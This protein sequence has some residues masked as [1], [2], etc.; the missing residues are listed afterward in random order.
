[1]KRKFRFWTA[2]AAAV[3]TA[4]A[5]FVLGFVREDPSPRDLGWLRREVGQGALVHHAAGRLYL[6]ELD[7]GETVYIAPGN[8]PEFS[9]DSSKIAWIDG[10]SAKG[11]RRIGDTSVHTI[12]D[13]VE[14]AGGVH[15]LNDREVAVILVRNGRKSWNRVSLTGESSEIPALNRLGLGGY[16]CDVRQGRDGVWSYV[17]RRSWKT[18]DGKGGDLPG[19]CSV[20]ISPDGRSATSLHNPHKKC[21]IT[22]IRPGGLSAT[23]SW[24]F[25]GGFDN[26]R[27]SS[28]DPRYIVCVDEQFQQMA[29][30]TADGL[31]VTRMSNLGR[32]K[33]QMYGDFTVGDGS[34]E[35]WPA[36]AANTRDSAWPSHKDGLLFFWDDGSESNALAS[37]DGILV[38]CRLVPRGRARLASDFSMLID[39]G[40]FLVQ[41][42]EDLPII[43]PW[44]RSWQF[45]FEA[46]VTPLEPG[47]GETIATLGQPDGKAQ[48]VLSQE[49]GVL[50]LS[51]TTSL[52]QFRRSLGGLGHSHPR[53]VA[54]TYAPGRLQAYVDGRRVLHLPEAAGDLRSWR[55]ARM[56]LGSNAEGLK[57]WKGR[58]RGLA[59]YDRALGE[60][61]IRSAYEASAATAMEGPHSPVLEVEAT[62]LAKQRVP[63]AG[64]YPNAL[65]V[66]VYQVAQVIQGQNPG[67]RLA[68]AG[69]GVL[70][71]SPQSALRD[72]MI[73]RNYLLRLEPFDQHPQLQ[74]TKIALDSD[75]LDLPLFYEVGR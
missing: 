41:E 33:H 48:F 53:H 49:D 69:W 72:R 31:R 8:Q 57:G 66:Y 32:A 25:K 14:P 38:P 51:F 19:T 71:G 12:A 44:M 70:N 1:M 62:L 16:E 58:I 73:G 60:E 52:G 2:G 42:S 55:G 13:G 47:A 21:S 26:H 22:P 75:H 20:S 74:R 4:A 11:R 34:G 15:W 43:G 36:R 67:Q 5:A 61:E 23:L 54:I 24:P 35:P 39:Q 18:S 6:T 3:A 29:I 17:A 9:P 46:V 45:T 27:W 7:S 56:L 59:L 37:D 28:N 64:A 30:M 65:V 10:D 63:P 50:V 68:A 40:H